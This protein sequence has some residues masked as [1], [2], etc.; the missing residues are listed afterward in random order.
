MWSEFKAFCCVADGRSHVRGRVT[1]ALHAGAASQSLG[2]G[3]GLA[4][5]LLVSLECDDDA[6][7][8]EAFNG[9]AEQLVRLHPLAVYCF[10]SAAADAEWIV[11]DSDI[12]FNSDPGNILIRGRGAAD[13]CEVTGELISLHAPHETSSTEEV[14]VL[15]IGEAGRDLD[16]MTE[17]SNRIA[18]LLQSM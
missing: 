18:E 5:N 14:F 1:N 3:Y 12:L 8:H 15:V 10:G 7:S 4:A 11:L 9:L 2:D 13:V 17:T 6:I 16:W